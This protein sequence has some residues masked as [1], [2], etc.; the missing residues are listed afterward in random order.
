L[1]SLLR[2]VTSD[3]RDFR[4]VTHFFVS[5]ELGCV[6]K[7]SLLPNPMLPILANQHVSPGVLRRQFRD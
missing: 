4:R 3:S 2:L 6:G 5:R 1:L 7:N